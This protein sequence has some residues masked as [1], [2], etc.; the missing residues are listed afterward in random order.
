MGDGYI[1]GL[2]IAV[3]KTGPPYV[4]QLVFSVTP[5]GGGAVATYACGSAGGLAVPLFKPVESL[6]AFNL[7]TGC[8]AAGAGRRRLAQTTKTLNLDALRVQAGPAPAGADA[9]VPSPELNGVPLAGTLSAAQLAAVAAA[10]G[11][12]GPTVTPTPTPTPPGPTPP[13]PTPTP[14]SAPTVTFS[15]ANLAQNAATLTIAGTGFDASTPSA[16]TVVLSSGIG[17]VTAATP[18]SLT[19]TF[20]SSPS[21]GALTAVVTSF[22]GSS[23]AAVQVATVVAA[24]TVPTVTQSYASLAQNA[25]TLAIAGTGFDASTPAANT[26]VLSS[27]AGTVTAATPTSLTVTFSS[28]PGLGPLTAVVTSFGMSSGSAVR[29]GTVNS[30][31]GTVLYVADNGG[32]L[33]N[34]TVFVCLDYGGGG[35][36]PALSSCFP[37]GSGFVRPKAVFVSGTYGSY[38]GSVYVVD[39][40]LDSVH[41]CEISGYALTSCSIAGSGFDNPIDIVISSGYAYVTNGGSSGYTVASVSVCEVSSS[42]ALSSCTTSASGYYPRG[43]AFPEQGYGLGGYAYVTDAVSSGSFSGAVSVWQVSSSPPAPVLSNPTSGGPTFISGFSGPWG[44]KVTLD[45]YV[46][47][48]NTNGAGGG[49]VSVCQLSGSPPTPS[50]CATSGSGFDSPTGIAVLGSG[51]GGYAYVAN[52][53]PMPSVAGGGSVSIC[54]VSGSP[55]ALSSCTISGSFTQPLGLAF[56]I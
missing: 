19:V 48:V 30:V 12:A 13:G 9:P 52:A 7:E 41:R 27:G 15:S 23:G 31:G 55:P 17:T 8:V 11:D 38:G 5:R 14:P 51:A 24:P 28:P 47:V 50:S 21:V 44:I 36:P 16:N 56:L 49:S 10:N 45:G 25:T 54:R 26:V 37:T 40:Y 3:A 29:V 4:G 32:T 18:T 22:G 34:G 33:G 43:I 6:A 2:K 46:F 53:G 1:S 42:G 39:G 35:S 20:S